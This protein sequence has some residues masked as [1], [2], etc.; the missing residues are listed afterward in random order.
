MS[1]QKGLTVF[2]L[3]VDT[4]EIRDKDWEGSRWGD[5]TNNSTTYLS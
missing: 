2:C 1:V 5:K 3:A 4:V